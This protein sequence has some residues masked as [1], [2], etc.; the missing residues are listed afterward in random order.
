MGRPR[1][2][3]KSG[4]TRRDPSPDLIAD[5]RSQIEASGETVK[6]DFKQWLKK[7]AERELW[8]FSRWIL[9][10]DHLSLGTFHRKI[11]CPFM[12]TVPAD[13]RAKL[14]MLPMGH[15]KTTVA[16]RS[17]PLHVLIQPVEHNVY[18]PYMRGREARIL[19]GNENEQKCKENMDVLKRQSEENPWLYW[20]WPDVFWDDP[21]RDSPRWSDFQLEFRRT[22]IFAE[23]SIAIVGVQTG[24]IGRYYDLII[25]DDICGLEASQNPQKMERVKKWRRASKTRFYIKDGPSAGIYLGVGTHWGSEDVYVEW[26]KDAGLD[27]LIKSIEEPDAKGNLKPLWPEKFPASLIDKM[28]PPNSDAI[29]WALWYMNKPVPAGYTAMDWSQLRTYQVTDGG[30][31]LVFADDILDERIAKRYETKTKNLGFRLA[32]SPYDPANAKIRTKPSAGMD[33]SFFDYMREKYPD[34]IATD[35]KEPS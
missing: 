28:R 24:F 18:F 3:A 22:G 30:R 15:L 19:L 29:E 10:N 33:P 27:L 35:V 13:R 2:D 7:K 6:G 31:T 17:L 23:A 1:K 32:G 21:K 11:V 4:N 34:R 8:F 14:L 9:G 20:L 16:S 25:A 5:L 26:K 12:S